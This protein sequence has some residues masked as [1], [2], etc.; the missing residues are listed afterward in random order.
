MFGKNALTRVVVITAIVAGG[1]LGVVALI[2]LAAGGGAPR[3]FRHAGATVDERKSLSVAGVDL[4]ALTTVAD[5]IRVI[6]GA[7]DSVEA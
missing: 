1:C 7:G 6:D 3:A 2:G 4:V 5:N